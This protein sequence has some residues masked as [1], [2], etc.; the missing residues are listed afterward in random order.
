MLDPAQNDTFMDHY[1]DA[2]FDLSQVMFVATANQAENIPRPLLDRME[3]IEVPGYTTHEKAAIGRKHLLPRTLEAH[4]LTEEMMPITDEAIEKIIVN[5]TREAGVR[6][7]ERRIAAVCRAVAVGIVEGKWETKSI[8]PDEVLEFLGPEVHV[9][10]AAERTELPGIATGMAWTAA[11]GD[12]LFIEATTMPGGGKLRLTGSLGDVMKE[13]V[14]LALSYIRSK[15]SQYGI[16]EASFK[17]MDFHV[18]VPQG[19]IPKDGPSAGVTMMTALTSVLTGHRVKGTV[20]MTG[21]FTL[22]GMVLPVGG[23]K[24]KVLAAHRSG[25]ETIILPERNRK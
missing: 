7:L 23:I 5:Y 13:S 20:S 17:E 10:D 18:H 15:A 21:E 14:E 4:G 12:I 6:N 1:I 9:P 25:I 8:E 19:A 24:E 16:D 3:M 22:R 11:G 2:P